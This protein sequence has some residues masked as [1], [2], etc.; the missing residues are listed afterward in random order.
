MSAALY[1]GRCRRTWP[2]G[3]R[4][5]VYD[6]TSLVPLALAREGMPVEPGVGPPPALRPV[7]EAARPYRTARWLPEPWRRLLGSGVPD[8][9]CAVLLY[10][11]P[12]SGKS[13]AALALLGRAAK[14]GL[15]AAYLDAEMGEGPALR[16]L[17]DRAG[18]SPQARRGLR[19]ACPG[20]VVHVDTLV[21]GLD[22]AVVDSVQAL[23]AEP[24]DVARWGEAVPF[25]AVV[26]HVRAD[27]RVRGGL[28]VAHGVDA[29]VEFVAGE[30]ARSRK[31]RFGATPGTAVPFEAL[32]AQAPEPPA[33]RPAATGDGGRV[34]RLFP[35]DPQ[36][37]RHA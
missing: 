22:V 34:I 5:C 18:L 28:E 8:A 29:V 24:G 35:S 4:D 36:E 27:G 25:L 37:P 7:E 32:V 21:Q 33:R 6:G 23:R 26:S 20:G 30:G 19:C 16:A 12:G 1:C 9:R 10:G 15:R 17:L 14:A 31:S 13:T 3:M 2:P 11:P